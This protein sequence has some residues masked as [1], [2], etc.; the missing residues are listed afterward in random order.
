MGGL[1]FKASLGKKQVSKSL[2]QKPFQ[3]WFYMAV[4]PA[5]REVGVGG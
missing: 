3:E 1:W 5:V 2:S 4:I